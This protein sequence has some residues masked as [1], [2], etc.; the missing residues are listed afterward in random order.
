LGPGVEFRMTI[1]DDMAFI[2]G[3]EWSASFNNSLG[4]IESGIALVGSACFSATDPVI[5]LGEVYI[6][7]DYVVPAPTFTANIVDHPDAS[8][9]PGIW[10]TTCVTPG[11]PMARVLGGTF[12]FNGS[13]NP[14]VEAKSW[15]AIK[16]LF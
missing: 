10:I 1:S 13:C 11:Y 16:S 6:M 5:Y 12:V 9:S 15:G 7:L 2:T 14:G 8:P 4:D 3:V